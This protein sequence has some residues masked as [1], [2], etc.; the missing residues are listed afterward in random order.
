M[1]RYAFRDDIVLSDCAVEVWGDS[2]ADL[3]E[4][5]ARSVAE[6]MAD[7]T[8]VA[9]RRT[10]R[11]TLEADTPDL[12]LVEWL[13]EILFLKDRDR[14]IYP[15]A[16]VRVTGATESDGGASAAP[17]SPLRLEA[18]L[19]GDVVNPETTRRGIDVKAITLHRLS[20]ERGEGGWHGHFVV[21]L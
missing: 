11:V 15:R 16:E 10:A 20:V 7:P 13:G 8:S 17:Q 6:L 18:T 12:L 19:H 1:G 14:A 2:L 3:L 21:D 9:Q 4:T 5:A